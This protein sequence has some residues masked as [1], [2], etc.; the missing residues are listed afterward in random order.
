MACSV[1]LLLSFV[2]YLLFSLLHFAN[3]NANARKK[4]QFVEILKRCDNVDAKLMKNV[5]VGKEKIE[6]KK[7]ANKTRNNPFYKINLLVFLFII[8]IFT[9]TYFVKY[10]K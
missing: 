6:K 9:N 5:I 4:N 1:S 8:L 3:A 2:L 7:A 10:G